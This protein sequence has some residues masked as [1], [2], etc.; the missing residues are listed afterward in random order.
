VAIAETPVVVREQTAP[1]IQWSAVFA[2]A[3]VAAAISSVLIAFASAAG[4]SLASTAPTWRDASFALWLLAGV[5]LVLVALVSFGAG[6]YVAGR[7]RARQVVT[8]VQDLEFRDGLHGLLA[9]GLA[10]LFAGTLAVLALPAATP[11]VAPA[12]GAGVSSSPGG[13]SLLAYEVD[14][15][16]RTMKPV[17]AADMTYTR[18]EASRILLT[19]GSHEGVSGD[20]RL[21]LTDLVAERTGATDEEAA[22]RVNQ[23]IARADDALTKARHAAVL[24]AFMTAAALLLGAVVAWFA[25]HSGGEDRERDL[26]PWWSVTRRRMI[27]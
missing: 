8:T 1:F 14:K 6:G 21:Y 10:V 22:T 13:E 11:V 18:A 3:I 4:F 17:S 20:D 16:F 26:A 19:T 9:W 2:G 12:G 15:L 5:L 7:L 27:A 23:A 24:G 25:A